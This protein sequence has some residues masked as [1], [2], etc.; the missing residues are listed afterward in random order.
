M[1]LLLDEHLSP[2]LVRRLQD[3]FPESVHVQTLGLEERT[4]RSGFM[5]ATPAW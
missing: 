1:R 5:R 4:E 2:R 3:L